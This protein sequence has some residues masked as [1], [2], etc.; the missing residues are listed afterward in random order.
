MKIPHLRVILL[1]GILIS[2]VS[3]I[4]A[5]GFLFLRAQAAQKNTITL[6]ELAK[7]S[8][9]KDCYVAY[10]GEVFDLSWFVPL[11]KGG[12]Q[13]VAACGTPT[14]EFS[15]VHPGGQ[16]SKITIQAVLRMSVIG[17]LSK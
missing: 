14:D 8:T 6:T 10:N 17:T 5:S 3:V 11:H 4:V 1:A 16:F 7:H 12:M 13:I 9:A 15:K 2:V